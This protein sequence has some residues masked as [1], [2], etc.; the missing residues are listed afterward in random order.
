MQNLSLV[1]VELD[2]YDEQA[3]AA[4]IFSISNE[5]KDSKQK[6]KKIFHHFSS[7]I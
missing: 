7:L 6:K 3:F 5:K 2:V 4:D 1:H